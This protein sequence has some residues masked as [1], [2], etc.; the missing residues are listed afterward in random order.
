MTTVNARNC[1]KCKKMVMVFRNGYQMFSVEIMTHATHIPTGER[2]EE[3]ARQ[4]GLMT[5]EQKKEYTARVK[6]VWSK[7]L[8]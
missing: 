3:A 1:N 2:M 7:L 5:D 4:W 8:F 6:Q